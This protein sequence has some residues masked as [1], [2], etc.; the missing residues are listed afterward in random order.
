MIKNKV[1]EI[2]YPHLSQMY[3]IFQS[4]NIDELQDRLH[5]PCSFFFWKKKLHIN[6]NI[7][8][9][10]WSSSISVCSCDINSVS[11]FMGLG[12][13]PP[14]LFTKIYK[15]LIHVLCSYNPL[16]FSVAYILSRWWFP[17]WSNASKAAHANWS[18]PNCE[19]I[20]SG[21][22]LPIDTNTMN[23]NPSF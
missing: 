22:P 2:A 23:H 14:I 8:M 15:E 5:Q 16:T 11:C 7:A 18:T 21:W 13:F 6:K 20:A 9:Y 19:H 3:N 10:S 12:P 17:L 4:R 1:P